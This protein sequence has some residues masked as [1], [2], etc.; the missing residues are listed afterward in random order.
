M[1]TAM[2]LS[3]VLDV[4][5]EELHQSVAMAFELAI[6]IPHPRATMLRSISPVSGLVAETALLPHEPGHEQQFRNR[7][8][9]KALVGKSRNASTVNL[10]RMKCMWA[11]FA[12][13]GALFD[14]R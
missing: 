3:M 6:D 9:E 2:C 7:M 14:G 10:A 11:A 12:V 4:I 8:L 5:S 13:T 1:A